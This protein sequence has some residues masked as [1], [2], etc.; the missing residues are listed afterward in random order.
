MQAPEFYPTKTTAGVPLL[1]KTELDVNATEFRPTL[2][3]RRLPPDE[4]AAFEKSFEE[5]RV[6]KITHQSESVSDL[7]KIDAIQNMPATSTLF[8]D[9]AGE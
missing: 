4:R 7:P 2:G 3:K 8:H 6:L 5:P 9:E 1:K